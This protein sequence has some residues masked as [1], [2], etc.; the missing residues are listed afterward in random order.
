MP[1]VPRLAACRWL[2]GLAALRA[3]RS[4]T[5]DVKP[6]L[7]A[8]ATCHG[9]AA[10]VGLRL[11]HVEFIRTGG[12]SGHGNC[13]HDRRE[14]AGAGGHRH[15]RHRTDAAGGQAAI[16]RRDR[17]AAGL[18]RCRGAG[19]R[20]ATAGR[21]AGALGVS[22]ARAAGIAR[23]CQTR[24]GGASDRSLPGRRARGQRTRCRA[25]R[26]TKRTLLRRVYLDLV[27]SAADARRAARIPGRRRTTPTRKS[28]TDCWPARTTASVG[29]GIGW[30]CGATAT[31]TATAP[32]CAKASRTSGDGATGSSS[33]STPT[34]PTTR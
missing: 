29:A 10:E 3:W 34:S 22:K 7:R 6:I 21:S 12:D 19:A 32:R 4:T 13:R 20:R 23:R 27:G 16:R 18:G 17:H 24:L 8:T 28:S 14:P 5:R 9:P 33:R 31:G 2:S 25:R 11:D 26:P 1:R 30:T 15:G